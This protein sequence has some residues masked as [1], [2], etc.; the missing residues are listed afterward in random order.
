M[1]FLSCIYSLP[2]WLF[3]MF[4]ER[5]IYFSAQTE[6]EYSPSLAQLLSASVLFCTEELCT[7]VIF[8]MELFPQN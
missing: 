8:I 1:S 4:H 5:F 7:I 3:P 6:G 2:L